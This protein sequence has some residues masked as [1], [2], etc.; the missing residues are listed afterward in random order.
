MKTA[1]ELL[2]EKRLAK[3]LSI[4]AVAEKI[5]IKPEYL[6][7]LEE[8]N[9][10]LLP[11]AT[12]AKGFLRNYARFLHINPET[13]LAMFRR[14]FVENEKGEIM[15]RGLVEPVAGRGKIIPV[16]LILGVLTVVAFLAFL[17]FELFQWWSLPRLVVL[18]PEEGAVYGE[19]VTVKGETNP[20]S[21]VAID[22]QKVIVDPGGKFSLDL[23]FPAGTH[24]V[25]VEAT[26][27][28][29][30]TKLL[31]RTFTVSK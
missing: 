13:L 17:G 23:I 16:N 19:K 12:F 4:E 25:L 28:Q 26:N 21:A 6:S 2:K 15:P 3:E 1:G 10:S 8:S 11:S 18:S 22:K 30:K 20:D 29:G 31:E 24:S 5:K 9:F 14:D 7:A 27:R